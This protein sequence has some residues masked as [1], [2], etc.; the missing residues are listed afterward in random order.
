VTKKQNSD[1]DIVSAITV[2]GDPTF[3]H[4]QSFDAGTDTTTNGVSP[5]AI[6]VSPHNADQRHRSSREVALALLYSTPTRQRFRA[7][8]IMEMCTAL[9]VIILQPI[10]RK[11]LLGAAQG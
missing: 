9:Q 7:T 11:F 6:R 1:A 8:V 5:S 3:T 4:G 10:V 2:F